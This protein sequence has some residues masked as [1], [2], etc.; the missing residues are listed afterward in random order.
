MGL[1]KLKQY[2]HFQFTVCINTFS[3]VLVN[4]NDVLFVTWKTASHKG[5]L[6]THTLKL[7]NPISQTQIINLWWQQKITFEDCLCLDIDAQSFDTNPLLF[8]LKREKPDMTEILGEFRTDLG[9]CANTVLTENVFSVDVPS[10]KSS[11][12]KANITVQFK[13][14]ERSPI[15]EMETVTN[16]S[17]CMINAIEEL[18]QE[19]AR[20]SN[21]YLV[22]KTL[23]IDSQTFSK[24][25]YWVEKLPDMELD[26]RQCSS[27]LD[28]LNTYVHKI[29]CRLYYILLF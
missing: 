7:D 29:V 25:D 4:N 9:L 1:M 26:V 12:L 3:G 5:K 17:T 28:E 16:E 2:F 22:L 20:V 11:F 10:R 6:Q 21:E 14:L 24:S 18:K 23:V 13:L 15:R 27:K 19:I 8:Q